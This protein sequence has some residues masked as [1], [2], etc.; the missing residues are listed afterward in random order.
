V[1]R[2]IDRFNELHRFLHELVSYELRDQAAAFFERAFVRINT[3]HRPLFEGV[4]V[5]GN[6]ELDPIALRR[7]IATREIAAYLRGLDRLIE[8]E[9]ELVREVLGERKAAIIQDGLLAL[10]QRQ[11]EGKSGT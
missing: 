1:G 5:D 6:G 11:L 3:E 4:S 2:E 9:T 7:N 10:K 8:I